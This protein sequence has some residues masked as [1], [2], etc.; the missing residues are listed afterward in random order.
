MSA[1]LARTLKFAGLGVSTC[2]SMGGDRITGLGM[3]DHA[4]L[5]ESDPDTD[6]IVV[7]GEPGTR[8]ER[9]L[10]AAL[11]ERRVTKP[12]I[13]LIAGAFQE[14]Y[15]AGQTFGHAA[16]LIRDHADTASA[17]IALLREAGATVVQTLDEIPAC[18]QTAL[19]AAGA[20]R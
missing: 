9:D 20:H 2:V 15:P 10:A 11:R 13:A 17:K 14:H 12:V 3:A 16:A 4:L 18:I 1:E 7:F 8:N 5:F 6:A 19:A